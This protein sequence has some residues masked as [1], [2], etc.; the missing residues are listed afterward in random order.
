ML[1]CIFN[2]VDKL[3]SLRSMCRAGDLGHR[4]NGAVIEFLRTRALIATKW[5]NI[6]LARY[7]VFLRSEPGCVR[8][9]PHTDFDPSKMSKVWLKQHEYEIAKSFCASTANSIGNCFNTS[10]AYPLTINATAVSVLNPR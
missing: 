4:V 9:S 1:E 5:H 3:T 7:S 2:E 6:E 8:Q 10:L